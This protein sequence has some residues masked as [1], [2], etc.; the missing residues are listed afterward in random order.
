MKNK[1]QKSID[2][3]ITLLHTPPDY[4]NYILIKLS[5]IPQGCCCFHC[6]P[7]TWEIINKTIQP[8]GPIEN[9]GD[10]LIERNKTKIV[11]ECHESGPEIIAYL[12]LAASSIIL[13]KSIIDLLKSIIDA[14]STESKK[15][16]A[17][18][19][20]SKRQIIKGEV[21]EE[22]LIEL[23]IPISKN[24]KKQLESRLNDLINKNP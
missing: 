2:R 13:L 5:P 21:E 15:Q 12:T 6:W 8:Y 18:I 22:N 4:K 3:A 10:V 1:F 9:E 19:K 7:K 16:P 17:R 24:I 11:L 14:L 20:I 23:D